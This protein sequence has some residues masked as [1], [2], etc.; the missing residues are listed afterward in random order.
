MDKEIIS[1]IVQE[2][3]PEAVKKVEAGSKSL[4]VISLIEEHSSKT[5]REGEQAIGCISSHHTVLVGQVGNHLASVLNRD[6]PNH[7]FTYRSSW[8]SDGQI[9]VNLSNTPCYK[10]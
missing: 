2:I 3:L 10:L 8:G 7:K 1:Q 5:L 4:N 9:W 6:F